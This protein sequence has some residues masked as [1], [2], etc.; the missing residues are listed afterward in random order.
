MLMQHCFTVVYVKSRSKKKIKIKDITLAF[1][2][3]AE[4]QEW[5]QL[6]AANAGSIKA[7]PPSLVTHKRGH[8]DLSSIHPRDQSVMSFVESDTPRYELAREV[9]IHRIDLL[10]AAPFFDQHASRNALEQGLLLC[11]HFASQ[12]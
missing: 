8:S 3:A 11:A 12:L 4:A 1:E 7:A 9:R 5:T 10:R 2:T 6:I